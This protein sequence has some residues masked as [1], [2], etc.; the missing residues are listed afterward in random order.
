MHDG[1]G[2]TSILKLVAEAYDDEQPATHIH[3]HIM[4]QRLPQGLSKARERRDRSTRRE[5]TLI[6]FVTQAAELE[7]RA[8][9]QGCI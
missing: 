6:G 4:A 9:T 5:E 2:D 3:P 1:N 7:A 8:S